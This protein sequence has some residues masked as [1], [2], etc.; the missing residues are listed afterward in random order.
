MTVYWKQCASK[1]DPGFGVIEMMIASI[2]LAF[3]LLAVGPLLYVAASSSSLSR[4]KDAAV[5]AA[6]SKLECLSALYGNNPS[7]PDL[8][9][10]NHGPQQVDVANPADDTVMN[11][12]NLNWA[13]QNVPDPRPHKALDAI[14]V[15]ITVTPINIGGIQNYRPPFNKVLNITTIISPKMP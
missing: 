1:K 14:L 8:T 12:F 15:R 3:G 7:A 6:Q 10:G 2:I 5:V 11:R 9:L 4:A 13:I